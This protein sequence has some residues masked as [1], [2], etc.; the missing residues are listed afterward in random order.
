[1]Q[2]FL[3]GMLIFGKK[4]FSRVENFNSRE[5][6]RVSTSHSHRQPLRKSGN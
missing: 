1:M 3:L 4:L 6:D 5:L 2:T